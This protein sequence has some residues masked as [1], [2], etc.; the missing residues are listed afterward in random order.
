M[1]IQKCF[2]KLDKP[3]YSLIS[4]VSLS[5][6]V[7]IGD[8]KNKVL[9]I[10][11][12]GA[13]I[14]VIG[15]NTL[16]SCFSDWKTQLL[17]IPGPK[18]GIAANNETFPFLDTKLIPVTI[19]GLTKNIE[20]AVAKSIPEP[21]LGLNCLNAFDTKISFENS[22]VIISINDH[23]FDYNLKQTYVAHLDS[24]NSSINIQKG[25]TKTVKH[26]LNVKIND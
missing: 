6:P 14:S 24:N 20:F 19:A 5:L 18:N 7:F 12:S 22:H 3:P 4:N 13:Q 10:C 8:L 1:C 21:L 25:V 2:K 15:A 17:S 9:A 11:D 26:K 16:Q 23:N